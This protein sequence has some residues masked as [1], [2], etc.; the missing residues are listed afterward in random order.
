[1]ADAM[2]AIGQ[3]VQ[4]EAADEL[5]RGERHERGRVAVTIIAPAEGHA[6][7]VGADQAAVG[8]GYPVG[9][10][11]EIGEDM[12]GRAERLLGIDNP[13]FAT[14]RPDR[15]CEGMGITE[16]AE[17]AGE[18]QSPGRM[19]RLKPLEEQPPEQAGEN[20]DGQEEARPAAEPAPIGRARAAGDK[21][22]DVR[23]V[24]ERLAPCVKNG[25]EP[26]LAAEVPRIDVFGRR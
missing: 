9:V 4:E 24:D 11:A 16:H 8:D 15:S 2:E 1:M 7:L 20:M 13:V 22:M 23:M 12:L 25:E 26:D 10:A 17:R 3:A 6:G 18:A 5:M 14:K 19:C 21:T